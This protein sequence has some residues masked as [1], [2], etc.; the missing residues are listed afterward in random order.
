LVSG[1]QKEDLWGIRGQVLGVGLFGYW[2]KRGVKQKVPFKGKKGL[3]K[4][5]LQVGLNLGSGIFRR[6]FKETG[7]LG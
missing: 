7:P 6:P 3:S 5:G 1:E 4:Q 2:E